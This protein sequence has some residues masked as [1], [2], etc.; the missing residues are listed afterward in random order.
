M[1]EPKQEETTID[2]GILIKKIHDAIER[3]ANQ[4]LQQ[5]DLTCSQLRYLVYLYKRGGNKIPLK[6]IEQYFS[7]SQP[8]VVGIIKRLEK[9]ALIYLTPDETDQRVKTANLTAKGYQFYQEAENQRSQM[10]ALLMAPLTPEEYA[11]LQATLKKIY[12]NIKSPE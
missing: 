6:E 4:S 9:K 11:N 1:N 3:A 8:T 10:E 7:V 12:Q 2:C 5:I